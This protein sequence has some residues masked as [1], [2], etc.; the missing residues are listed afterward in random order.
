MPRLAMHD[1]AELAELLGESVRTRETIRE[2]PLSWTQRIELADG[3]TFAYKS[4][5]PPLIEP[6]LYASAK[7]ALLPGHRVLGKL[8]D[9][10]TVL[11]DWID[12]P[13]LLDLELGETE[14]L[15]HLTEV[16]RQI[17]ELTG[18]PPT[19]LDIGTPEKWRAEVDLTLGKLR[20][21]VADETF[22]SIMP[23]MIDAIEAWSG[24]P[25]VVRT[26]ATSSRVVHRDLK[27][28]HIFVT[29][30][31]YRVIDWSV[32]AVAPGET[33]LA[34]VLVDAGL[35]P[36]AHVDPTVCAISSFL[37]L[38]WAVSAQH[39]MFPGPRW[40]LFEGWAL[41]GIHGV[42]AAVARSE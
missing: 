11:V 10:S 40:D 20:R 12:A 34:L 31:G 8:L 21:L 23:A 26:V 19:Y 2:W 6:E 22:T 32:P 9:C 18:H 39:D 29:D 15:E 25:E 35:D 17:G 33:D 41:E 16:V 5:L 38:R 37:H 24:T 28:E 14:L 30:G 3:R 36:L 13:S 7:S 1:D 27:L 4:Q 42:E